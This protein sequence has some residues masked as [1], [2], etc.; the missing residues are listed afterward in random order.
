M[1]KADDAKAI[2]NRWAGVYSRGAPT[3]GGVQFF[4]RAGHR[5]VAL[6]QIP[7]GAC[8]LDVGTGRGANLFPASEQVGRDGRVTGVDLADGMVQETRA[9]VRRRGLRNVDVHHMDAEHLAF[10][11]ASFDRVLCGFVLYFLPQIHHAFTEFARVLK[12]GGVLAITGPDPAARD[13]AN[14]SPLWDLLPKYA[15]KSDRLRRVQADNRELWERVHRKAWPERQAAGALSFPRARELEAVVQQAGFLD[16]K[17]IKEEAEI[18]AADEEEWWTW[19]WF[20]MPRSMLEQM[21]PVVLQ[22]FKEAVF[23]KLQPRRQ[24]DGIHERVH[25]LFTLATKPARVS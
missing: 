2:K 19:Q 14:A 22:E 24:Q 25:Y 3:Y 9:E 13:R 8:V 7:S 5:L 20:H 11:N 1:N 6:A 21:E 23:K 10:L 15:Q 12:P 17:V 4:T 18:I 16:I